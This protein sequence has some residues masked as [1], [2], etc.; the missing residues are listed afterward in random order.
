MAGT[1]AIP[2][3]TILTASAQEMGALGVADTLDPDVA[4]FLLGKFN[5]LMDTWN[6]Q[7]AGAYAIETL[8]FTLTPNLNP[9]TIGPAAS[10]PTWTRDPRP[11]DILTLNLVIS[12]SPDVFTPVNVRSEAWYS[13]LSVPDIMSSIPTDCYYK[14]GWSLGSFYFYPVPTTAYDVSMSVT[15]AFAQA[16]LVTTNI[17]LPPGYLNAMIMTIAEES[18]RAVTE[19]PPD[20]DL[21]TRAQKARAIVFGNNDITPALISDVPGGL[22]RAGILNYKSGMLFGR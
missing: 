19:Q 17:W 10:T 1:A 9:H 18:C 12:S 3:S 20:G 5:R 7:A 22:G 6:V 4:A 2:V 15:T 13:A 14:P 8:T 21:V 11:N 16:P